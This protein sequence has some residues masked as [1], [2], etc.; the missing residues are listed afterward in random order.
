M[1]KYYTF[2]MK[3]DDG[4]EQLYKKEVL[5]YASECKALAI[6]GNKEF[7]FDDKKRAIEFFGKLSSLEGILEI[8][9]RISSE[10]GF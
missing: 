8:N 10:I 6:F 2:T 1:E 5:D 7:V 4:K 3:F 9:T